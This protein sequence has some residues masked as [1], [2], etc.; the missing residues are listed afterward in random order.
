MNV[1]FLGGASGIGA[2]CTAVQLGERWVLVDAGIRMDPSADRL[3]D[4]SFLQGKSLAAIFVTHAHAD[5]IGALPLVHQAFPTVPIYASRATMLLMEVMLSDA[6]QVMERRATTEF[7]VPLYD[8][9]MVTSTLHH[10]YPLPLN[11]TVT[12][13]ELP[14]VTIH[15]ARAGHVAGAV[16]IG[17]DAP[18][19]RLLMSGDV[20]VTPQHTVPG[21]QLPTLKH[22]DLFVL[23]STYGARLHPNR[24]AEEERL[25]RSVAEG[26]ER[27][28]HVLIPAFALGRAQEVLRILHMAQRRG[29]IPEFPVWVDG[30]V[31]RVCATYTAMP[32]S[33][34]PML[35]RQIH[36]GYPPFFTGMVRAVPDARYRERVLQGKPSCIVSS[37][38][39][40]T[41]GPSAFYASHLA[42]NPD[43][44]I[45]IT[46]YQDDEAPGRKLLELADK[47]GGTLELNDQ[48]VTVRCQFNRYHL[49]A[50][51]DGTELTAMVS[52]LKPRRV[53]LVHGDIDSRVALGRQIERLTEVLLPTDGQVLE[54]VGQKKKKP[55]RTTAAPAIPR[56]TAVPSHQQGELHLRELWRTV[57][58][59]SETQIVSVRELAL[60]WYGSAAGEVEEARIRQMLDQ[61]GQESATETDHL[62][63]V[64]MPDLDGLYRVRVPSGEEG[65]DLPQ[66]GGVQPGR[67]L[68]LQVYTDRLL[69]VVCFDVRSEALWGYAPLNESSR[70]RFPRT[71]VL[72]VLGAWQPYPISDVAETRRRLADM[73][74]ATQRWRR[75]H[76]A[77]SVVEQMAPDYSYRFE[78][79]AALVGVAAD[80][81]EAR[82]AL[83]LLLHETPRVFVR[84]QE[85]SLST[86]HQR[87]AYTL[88]EEW[89][90]ALAEGA[91]EMRPDQ[92]WILS[93]VDKHL[94]DP[95]DLYR[96]GVNPDTGEVMLSFHFP[97]VAHTRY[98]AMLDAASEEAGV[99]ITIAPQPHQGALA[100]AA[101]AVLPATLTATRT[102]L[103]HDRETIRLRCT[104][105]ATP[106]EVE[107]A[108]RRFHEQTGWTLEIDHE[109]LSSP[110]SPLSPS[111]SSPP[112][113]PLSA[114]QHRLDLHTAMA[115]V[116]AAL[117]DAHDFYK[118]SADQSQGVLMVRFHF[119]DTASVR[120]ADRLTG[121]SNQTGWKVTVYPEP[122]QGAMET[123]VRRTMPEGVEVVGAPSLYRK[124]RQVTA[125]VRGQ[126]EKEALARAREAFAQATGWTLMV[127]GER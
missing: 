66:S 114:T 112:S 23:E 122:H 88:H 104:G 33:L 39:M 71:T 38:G 22:P 87:A 41:G 37:S 94:P 57:A 64:P 25:A 126:A 58:T 2:S 53:A 80:D 12:I 106:G 5:H 124:N 1:I 17:F 10:L 123:L 36:R 20:S 107:A 72:E 24:Q 28:G 76:P 40:L 127:Q 48:S 97:S 65:T 45:L 54:E 3:P 118:V 113:P 95:P 100:D 56:Q 9:E 7:E 62:F 18:D 31:R 27:G 79:L 34:T 83:A 74:K 14:D 55:Q 13:A 78:D 81:L 15:T 82:L 102:S 73:A 84:Q 115:L 68:L 11:D 110:S 125:K 44:S 30:L 67:L 109:S 47:N 6:L 61:A 99:P 120:Y 8:Q 77:R 26:I 103:H 111:S 29:Q 35:Q 4:L 16:S 43:A 46:G 70:T 121:L 93:V 21:A 119:P 86:L 63:F 105:K 90:A 60:A 42:G 32:E 92:T 51:A 49:S 50:H 116:R 59:G 19:G 85:S 98:R 75:Q 117:R 101:Q 108:V 96:R 89:E 52:A 91:G 69:P